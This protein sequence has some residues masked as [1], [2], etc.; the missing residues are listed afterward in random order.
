MTQ[1]LDDQV[2]DEFTRALTSANAAITRNWAPGLSDAEIDALL[3]PHSLDLP[4]EAR[5]WWR[6]H[7]GYL[8]GTRPPKADIMPRRVLIGLEET[9]AFY[10]ET[11][12][13]D[14]DV[15]GADRWLAPV[16]DVPRLW[17]ACNVA[18]HEPVPI[19]MQEDV[20]DPEPV[21]PSIG[22]LV[23]LWTELIDTSVF[24]ADAN[25]DWEWDF[26]KIPQHI[27]ELGVY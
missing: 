25:G 10:A 11:K 9:L 21:L 15:Y 17:F 6:W 5:R 1:L 12:D 27:R 24:T 19:Y 16:S 2:L 8:E 4:E 26:D 3:Q 23:K 14:R 7:N 18:I 22:E 20:D 13:T